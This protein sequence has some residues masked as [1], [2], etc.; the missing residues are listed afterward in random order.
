MSSK[1]YI[2]LL[3]GINVGGQKLIKMEALRK[4]LEQLPFTNISTYIQSGNI[5]FE[6]SLQSVTEIAELISENIRTTFSFDV[7]VIVV[8]PNELKRVIDNHPYPNRKIEDPAQPYVAF[9]SAI[10]KQENLTLLKEADFGKDEFVAAG[11]HMYLFYA[12][13]AARTKLSNAVLEKKLNVSSTARNWKT[14][15]KLIELAAG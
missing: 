11:K 12:E 6:S 7:P 8:T 1:K 14:I 13:S 2:A 4:S 5:L 15:H 10:P 3:R 9:F